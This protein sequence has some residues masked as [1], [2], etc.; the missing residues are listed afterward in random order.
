[1]NL[2]SPRKKRVHFADILGQD[3]IKVKMITPN[4]SCE[5]LFNLLSPHLRLPKVLSEAVLSKQF[6]FNLRQPLN[7][8][9]VSRRLTTQNVCL[10]NIAFSC[11]S[12]SGTVCVKNIAYEKQVFVRY[13]I[14]EW[15]T[16]HDK[17]ADYVPFSSDGITEKFSFRVSIP[18]DFVG[19]RII[20]AICYRVG[21]MEYWDNN[22]NDNYTVEVREE[23][24]RR[25]GN[26]K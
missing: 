6:V 12:M 7:E 22:F 17:W 25:M 19:R 1:M 20:F 5:N 14:D 18:K 4:N 13:T 9:Q 23:I 21:S 11:C 2:E 15:N 10:E 3:L 16:F 26:I 8:A 24:C